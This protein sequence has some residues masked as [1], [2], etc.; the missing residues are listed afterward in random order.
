MSDIFDPAAIVQNEERSR[1]FFSRH[2]F[3]HRIAIHDLID[4]ASAVRRSFSRILFI[5]R[6]EL[7]PL[8]R[9]AGY[10]DIVA[11][12]QIDECPADASYD[13]IF[14]ALTLHTENDVPGMLI[15]MRKALKP[16]GLFLAAVTGGHTLRELRH[17]LGAAEIETAGT[18]TTR[19]APT[20][21][22]QDMA[23]LMQR[24]GFAL[25]VVDS[26][27]VMATYADPV[28]LLRDLKGMGEGN[29]FPSAARRWMGRRILSRM[30]EIYRQNDGESDG[31]VKATFDLL[32]ACGWAPHESQPKP[33]KPGSATHRLADVLETP[34]TMT[35]KKTPG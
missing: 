6:A 33:L 10:P 20:I 13:L 23:A 7:V 19:L 32:Y 14:N 4:R 15:R 27:I 35:D 2:D 11:V 24:A 30:T 9:E 3:L 18:L 29:P 28:V 34:R 5:G 8:L 12:R 16:D 1:C 21:H 17:A 22:L 26:D 31:R 25:P